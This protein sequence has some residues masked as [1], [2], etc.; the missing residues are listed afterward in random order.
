MVIA[1]SCGSATPRR[2]RGRQYSQLAGE[3]SARMRPDNRLRLSVTSR[4]EGGAIQPAAGSVGA[5]FADNR[6]SGRADRT[7]AFLLGAVLLI[8]RLTTWVALLSLAPPVSAQDQA[9]IPG[10]ALGTATA[11][12]EE[13]FSSIRGIRALSD[14]R[15]LVADWI[16]ESVSLVNLDTGSISVRVAKGAGPDEVRLPGGL[17]PMNGDSTL[18]ADLGNGRLAVLAASGQPVRTI[19]AD[20]PG[21]IGAR[22]FARPDGI[23]FA[24]PPWAA[25]AE[26]LPND[27]V[28]LAVLDLESGQTK[29]LTTIQG[30]RRRKDQ[31]PSR[32]VRLPVIGFAARDAWVVGDNGRVIVVR[33]GTYRLEFYERDGSVL[34]GPEYAYSPRRVSHEDRVRFVSEFME[35]SAMSGRG[36]DGGLGSTPGVSRAEIERLVET[37]EFAEYHS[38]F[39]PDRLVPAAGGGAWVGVIAPEPGYTLYDVFDGE[40]HRLGRIRLEGQRR[41]AAVGEDAV[42]VIRTGELG[43][44]SIERYPRPF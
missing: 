12:L 17:W 14:G 38:F 29:V 8:V 33:A 18:L 13:A 39:L 44:E 22:G 10:R 24:V 9:T 32:Q 41:V 5:R 21:V 28:R 4:K 25:T 6:F 23:P 19:R 43:L 11:V 3:I 15:L 40:G 26:P 27:S 30:A 36:P 20:R 16:E 42:F 37:T 35:A 1:G 7:G 34:V 2:W 31:S